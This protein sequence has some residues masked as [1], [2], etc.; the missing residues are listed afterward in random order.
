MNNIDFNNTS[1]YLIL[2]DEAVT[3]VGGSKLT[4]TLEVKSLTDNHFT[5]YGGS[6]SKINTFVKVT[7]VQDGSVYDFEVQISS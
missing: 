3:A 5:I 6:D 2:R 4:I 1:T 7:G